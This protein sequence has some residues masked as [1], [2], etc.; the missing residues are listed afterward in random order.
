MGMKNGVY[1]ANAYEHL[2]NGHVTDTSEGRINMASKRMKK[3]E[4]M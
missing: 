2:E 3:Y 1:Y 4:A